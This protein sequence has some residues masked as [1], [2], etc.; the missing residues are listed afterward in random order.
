MELN[1]ANRQVCDLDIRVKK[2][3]E[4]YM[5]FETANTTTTSLSG[6][7]VY[8]MAKGSKR[9][10]FANPV[11]GTLAIEAQVYPFQMFALIAGGDIENDAVYA[12]HVV[13]EATADGELSLEVPK[14]GTIVDGSIFVYPK[15]DYG[16]KEAVMEATF[17]APAEGATEA[18]ITAADVKAG[19]KYEVGM[20]INRTGV[21]KVSFSNK[22][23][24]GDYFI[25]A[26]TLDKD[27]DGVF[28]PFKQ[29][30]YKATPQR[31]FELAF[32]SDGD[33][34]TVT[35]TFDLFEDKNGDFFD[36]LEIVDDAK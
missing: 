6:D 25:T 2:T 20:T 23:Q 26:T 27:E 30:F 13:V 24:P 28:T 9:I 31:N 22:K 8:A 32:S 21:Q 4:P 18:K 12:E 14:N 1:R 7:S 36:M 19:E 10:G 16:H 29:I 5:F 17:A 35:L 15:G 33:P 34:A 3:N 11:E